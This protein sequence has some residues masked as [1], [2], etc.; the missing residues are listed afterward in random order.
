VYGFVDFYKGQARTVMQRRR[1]RIR[2]SCGKRSPDSV[3]AVRSVGPRFNN[4]TQRRIHFGRIQLT[5]SAELTE[6]PSDEPQGVVPRTFLG[7]RERA[8]IGV[9]MLCAPRLKSCRYRAA[10]RSV[11]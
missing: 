10:A 5:A 1:F 11:L 4:R 2:R 6:A 8:Q 7:Y 3:Q 9:E